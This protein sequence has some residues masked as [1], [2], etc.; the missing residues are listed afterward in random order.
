M[1]KKN[2]RTH[3]DL[4]KSGCVLERVPSS[5]RFAAY[6]AS[7]ESGPLVEQKHARLARDAFRVR[8]GASTR[9]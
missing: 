9:S 1:R 8:E 6:A 3:P 2:S 4:M 5:L 7:L